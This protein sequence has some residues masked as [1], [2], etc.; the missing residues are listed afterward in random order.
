M[1]ALLRIYSPT[2]GIL[3]QTQDLLKFY[4]VSFTKLYAKCLQHFCSDT[5]Q[6]LKDNRIQGWTRTY[7]CGDKSLSGTGCWVCYYLQS[8]PKRNV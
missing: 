2:G 8:P 1:S 3:A 6:P 7:W 5:I 4:L